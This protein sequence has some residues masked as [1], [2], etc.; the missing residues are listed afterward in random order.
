MQNEVGKR[1]GKPG[2]DVKAKRYGLGSLCK[3]HKIR[4]WIRIGEEPDGG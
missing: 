2:C 4:N 3:A 1:G